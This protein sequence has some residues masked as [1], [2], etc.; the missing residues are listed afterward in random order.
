MFMNSCLVN[1]LN[2]RLRPKN[3]TRNIITKIVSEVWVSAVADMARAI[4]TNEYLISLLKM[5][6]KTR[7]TNDWDKTEGQC[8][9][10]STV[11]AGNEK[12]RIERGSDKIATVLLN[13]LITKY[14]I[15][16]AITAKNTTTK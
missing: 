2:T 10:K 6:Q 11:D 13:S 15:S 16:A 14:M 3:I 12:I 7:T 4:N 1:F 8:P 9:H 5:D